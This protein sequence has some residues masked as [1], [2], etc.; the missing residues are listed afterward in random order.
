MNTRC[1]LCQGSGLV[2]QTPKECPSCNGKK[3]IRCKES[4]F[5]KGCYGECNKCYGA[6]EIKI[7]KQT[8]NLLSHIWLNFL[9]SRDSTS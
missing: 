7:K 1:N 2:K 6:G 9:E 8:S 4:G 3:C 5:I